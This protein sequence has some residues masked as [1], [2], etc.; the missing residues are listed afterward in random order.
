MASNCA[1]AT[2]QTGVV[3]RDDGDDG[4]PRDA[5]K[6]SGCCMDGPEHVCAPL[7]CGC[8]ACAMLC[9]FFFLDEDVQ[10]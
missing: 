2:S 10:F 8:G 3:A 1:P 4:A 6:F 7:C 9:A 5:R